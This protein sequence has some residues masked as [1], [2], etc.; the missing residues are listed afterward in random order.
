MKK[1]LLT[2]ALISAVVVCKAQKHLDTL[3]S[4]VAKDSN[5][6]KYFPVIANRNVVK[7][8][9]IRGY[10]QTF[11]EDNGNVICHWTIVYAC[12]KFVWLYHPDYI[13]ADEQPYPEVEK[14]LL[15]D[16]KTVFKNTIYEF[17]NPAK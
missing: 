15:E 10:A 16:K 12:R 11:T 4:F 1:T 14:Y 7:R 17:I 8:D 9:T 5:S 6:Y 3:G 2:I 13:V